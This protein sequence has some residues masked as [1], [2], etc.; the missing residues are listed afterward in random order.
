MEQHDYTPGGSN[1][2]TKLK[3]WERWR[4]N[5]GW[6]EVTEAGHG[7]VPLT[8]HKDYQVTYLWV[9]KPGSELHDGTSRLI[10][11][12]EASDATRLREFLKRYG[13]DKVSEDQLEGMLNMGHPTLSAHFT[14][15]QPGKGGAPDRAYG[16]AFCG[17]ELNFGRNTG[18]QINNHSGRHSSQPRDDWPRIM[19]YVAARLSASLGIH[20]SVGD[21]K[22]KS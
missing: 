2:P 3:E 21:I 16:E 11:G 1:P 20:V 18:W 8:D 9:L 4:Y 12:F 6:V 13:I 10:I 19:V 15:E 7:F 22:I 5:P 14:D 17:G